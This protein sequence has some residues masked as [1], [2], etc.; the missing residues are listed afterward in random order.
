MIDDTDTSTETKLFRCTRPGCGAVLGL[1]LADGRLQ[2]PANGAASLCL[3]RWV[4]DCAVCGRRQCYEP[5][6]VPPFVDKHYPNGERDELHDTVQSTR[7][8]AD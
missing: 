7:E 8:R 1:V 4:G 2:V 5:P 6:R 3:V